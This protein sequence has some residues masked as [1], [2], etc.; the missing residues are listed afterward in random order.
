[1]ARP[2]RIER[3]GGIHH[4]IN[5]GSHRAAI[6]RADSTRASFLDCLAE[7]C[8]KTGWRMHAW[9]VLTNQFHL[10][11]ETPKANLVDGMRWL[12]GAFSTRLNRMR[13]RRGQIF[14][15]RYKSLI[16]DPGEGSG[17]L[18][19]YIHLC[20]VL[21]G[22][23]TVEELKAWPWSSA[24]WLFDGKKR[25]SWYCPDPALSHAGGLPDTPA[26]RRKYADYL[27]WLR[28]NEAERK[29]LR[30][31]RMTKGWVIGSAAFKK[32]AVKEHRKLASAWAA[33]VAG[34]EKA[35]E[36]AM[37]ET[38]DDLLRKAGRSRKDAQREG[39]FVPWKVAVAAAMKA[40]TTATNRWLGENLAMGSLH[41]ISRQVATWV[42]APDRALQRR[43]K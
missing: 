35:K 14:V 6:F 20:P 18:C 19:H 41:E 34:L 4:V 7:A 38:L 10:A 25:P 24:M 8:E 32:K 26:G 22:D 27:A 3:E 16:V 23:C 12:Q 15:G 13:S 42:R 17:P 29:A 40:R 28:K 5:R 30:F 2:L 37:Q 36:A 43:L 31:E 9:C 39:K 1:M 21:A 11:V 33:G